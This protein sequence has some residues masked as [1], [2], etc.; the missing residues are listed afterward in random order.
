MGRSN[1]NGGFKSR[2]T[3]KS[4]YDESVFM[5]S[6]I[7]E[8]D[9]MRSFAMNDFEA[10]QYCGYTATVREEILSSEEAQVVC[11]VTR[12]S[13]HIKSEIEGFLLEGVECGDWIITTGSCN[14]IKGHGPFKTME[15][16]FEYS[17][18]E[19]GATSFR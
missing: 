10:D 11:L 9:L 19:F 14:D 12:V 3:K 7:D 16:A 17:N 4:N 15:E 1:G 6:D 2:K 5:Y 18:K 13:D 8:D